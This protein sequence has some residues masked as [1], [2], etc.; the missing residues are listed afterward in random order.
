MEQALEPD[1]AKARKTGGG[2]EGWVRF[3]LVVAAVWLA[4][5]ILTQ[6]M[7][8]HFT[9]N[10]PAAAVLW[11][12]DSA[13][14]LTRLAQQRL[15]ARDNA[16]AAGLARRALE[17][18]PMD[19]AALAALGVALDQAGETQRADRVMDL[20]GREGWRDGLTQAWLYGRRML[21][22]R[23]ADALDR[24]DALLRRSTAFRPQIF[25]ALQAAAGEPRTFGPLVARLKLNPEWRISFL[26]FLTADAHP[27][28]EAR[29]RAILAALAKGP[30]PPSNAEISLYLQRL[31]QEHRPQEAEA[32]LRELS[33]VAPPPGEYLYNG[34]FDAPDGIAPFDWDILQGVG[35]N[36]LVTDSPRGSGKALHVSYDGFSAS[37][38]VRQLVALPPGDYVLSGDVQQ[39]TESGADQLNWTVTCVDDG[40]PLGLATTSGLKAGRWTSFRAP[41]HIP[42]QGC[43]SEWL[44]LSPVPGDRHSDIVVWYDDL[45]LRRQ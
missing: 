39:E 16:H 18:S 23:Y 44:Q 6:G 14:A 34:A 28:S 30:T 24:A 17:Q 10:N 40:H 41:I 36:A 27:E 22:G 15:A 33:A 12:G 2:R 20:A 31:V 29:A 37:Q 42:P 45:S 4:G 32:A 8:D 26:A 3:G 7:A 25:A 19:V 35:G 21:Q 43:A 13:D 38:F 1:P 11:R 9:A 5:Q